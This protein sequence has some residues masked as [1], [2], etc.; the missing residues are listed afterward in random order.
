MRCAERSLQLQNVGYQKQETSEKEHS[1]QH[2]CHLQPRTHSIMNSAKCMNGTGWR[3][4]PWKYI[5]ITILWKKGGICAW[6]PQ[7]SKTFFSFSF[8]Y[9]NKLINL[10]SKNHLHN[11]GAAARANCE[12]FNSEHHQQ[13]LINS[14]T[15][16]PNCTCPKC[17]VN[18]C[19]IR[20]YI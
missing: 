10:P 14:C 4:N 15:L 1:E 20:S 11:L 12:D 6:E 7:R 2:V 17:Q 3:Y 9:A 13:Q 19:R 16:K 18:F 8:E 5:S